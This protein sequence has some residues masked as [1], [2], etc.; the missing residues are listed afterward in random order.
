MLPDYCYLLVAVILVVVTL[1]L[2]PFRRGRRWLERALPATAFFLVLYGASE[3]AFRVGRSRGSRGAAAASDTVYTCSM[4]P[5]V[6]QN[7]PGLCP[8]CHM[9]LVQL[10]AVTAGAGASAHEVQIDPRVVQNMGVRVHTVARGLLQRSVRAFGELR[11]ADSR[12]HDIA[13][14]VDGFVEQLFA[15]TEG[16]A[17]ARGAPLFALY[18]ADLQVAQAELIAARDSND[19][20]LLAAARQ[21]L[22]LWDLDPSAI[23]RLESLDAPERLVQ[24]PSPFAGI[25]LQKNVVAGAP[26]EK[27]R[28]LLRIAD[29]SVLWLDAQVPAGQLAGIALGQDA[30]AE[31]PQQPGHELRGK[32]VF[33][34]PEVDR[35]TRTATVRI[36]LPN[37]GGHYKPGMYAL[38]HLR[39]PTAGEVLLAPAE[40]ILDTG[41]RRLAWVAVGL[42]RFE[43]RVVHASPSDDAGM[44]E[45]QDGLSVGDVVVVSGQFL[46]DAESRLREGMRK[47]ENDDLMP[48]GDLPPPPAA[49]IAAATQTTVDQLLAAYSKVATALAADQFDAAAWLALQQQAAA[50][51]AAPE[52]MVQQPAAE[53]ALTLQQRANDLESMRVAFKQVSSA[54]LRLFESARPRAAGA[55]ATKL[56]VQHCPMAEADWLQLDAATRNPYYG[57]S[58]L[59]CGAVRRELPLA[60]AAASPAEPVPPTKA[61]GK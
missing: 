12:Q 50:V 31:L 17:I 8:I 42:G 43:P 30:I 61:G 35:M 41:T 52:V 13:L 55:G 49:R 59:D 57:S 10:T 22:Q 51:A 56:F 19:A 3:A 46:I 23:A 58:M 54:A 7:E 25:L 4:H 38:V 32:V 1:A 28:V 33:I 21:K 16:M 11:I 24:W 53:L 37:P 40:A 27:N 15:D 26:A 34:A 36:E 39:T 47:F 48:G 5:Q 29:L 20:S 45:V 14:K 60:D 6:R 9:D 44:V 18:S 2:L